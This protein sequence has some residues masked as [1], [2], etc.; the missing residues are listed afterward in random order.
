M[1]PFLGYFIFI[2]LGDGCLGSKYGNTDNNVL[3]TESATRTSAPDPQDIFI[4]HY[5]TA[6]LDSINPVDHTQ[7]RLVISRKNGSASQY[8]LL[9]HSE[10]N[11]HQVLY[12]GEGM[13]NDG[14]LIGSYW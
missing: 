12:Y 8:S 7:A 10:S 2:N 13:L 4:G 11:V 9:W 5:V 3:L 14:R 6:W 1:N